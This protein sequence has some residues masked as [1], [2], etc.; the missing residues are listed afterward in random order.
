MDNGYEP[1]TPSLFRAI[2]D[3]SNEPVGVTDSAQR[4]VYANQAVGSLLGYESII[5]MSLTDILSQDETVY[6]HPQTLK[7]GENGNR[8]AFL[9]HQN[10]SIEEFEISAI[11]F[12]SRYVIYRINK[13]EE[14]IKAKLAT[15]QELYSKL[16]DHMP[17]AV[18]I[19]QEGIISHVNPAA[20]RL[21]KA[22]NAGQIIGMPAIELIHPDDQPLVIDRILTA[23]KSPD[24]TSP[25]IEEKLVALDGSIF[26]AEVANTSVM[27]DDTVSVMVMIRD[28][29]KEKHYKERLK[30]LNHNLE[31]RVESELKQRREQEQLLIQQSKLASMGEMI[32]AIAHQWRQPLNALAL[33][34]QDIADARD[35]GELD[36]AYL[37]RTVQQS[38]K[39]INYMSAT[40]D[41]FR[42]YF[43]SSKEKHSFNLIRSIEDVLNIMGTQM[44]HH[45]IATELKMNLACADATVYG[46]ENEL[47]QVLINIVNNAKDA[48]DESGKNNGKVTIEIRSEAKD[49]VNIISDSGV[50][51]APAIR[52]KIFDPYFT[53]KEQ[54]KGTGI[55]LYMAK[56]IIEQN[57]G[58]K[59]VLMENQGMTSFK[60]TLPFEEETHAD[61]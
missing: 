21:L 48:I 45:G 34:I 61:L 16:V 59:L 49:V 23:A 33:H 24:H 29:T 11:P 6:L 44:K 12:E 35:F 19:H 55:G 56:T 46:Y 20:L 26:Y 53:T 7:S 57:M 3:Q 10:G 28:I 40:I 30:E 52:E 15:A 47:K 13:L 36:D 14:K 9:K 25:P 41:D 43:K 54:G 51:I 42:N 17:D 60:I 50:G 22:K 1:I 2:V 4:F 5:G 39:Q 27:I 32:G 58:G 31:I 8:T 38:M 37:K 18:L